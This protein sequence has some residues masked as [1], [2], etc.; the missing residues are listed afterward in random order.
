[1]AAEKKYV[2][3]IAGRFKN[4]PYLTWDLINEPSFS[5]PKRPW[6]GNTPNADRTEKAAWNGW[7]SERYRTVQR[8]AEAWGVAVEDLPAFGDI[9]LPAPEELTLQRYGAERQVRAIDYNLFAQSMFARWVK[10]M[11]GAIRAAGA[12][13]AVTVGQDEGGVTDRVLNQFWGGAGVAMT[14]NHSW[15]RDDALLWDSVAAKRPDLPSIIGETGV[16]PAWRADAAWRWDEV[17]AF[18]LFERKM[19]LGLAGG[20]SGSLYWDWSR[21]DTFGIKRGDGSNKTWMDVLEAMCGFAAKAVRYMTGARK[22]DVA[23]VLPQSLQLSQFNSYALEA[24]QKAVRALFHYARATAYA[25]G[26]YQPDLLGDP[27][28]IILPSPW[29]LNETAWQAVLA[30]ARAGA[31]VL[32]SGRIDLDEYFHATARTPVEGYRPALLATRENALT[33]PGGQARLSYSGDKCT[34]L[35]RGELPDGNTFTPV[36]LGKGKVLYFSLPLELNDDLAAIG[37]V[38]RFALREAGVRQAYTTATA[39]P[40]LLLAPTQFDAATL[41]VLTS[42]SSG[43][44]DVSFRDTASG[45]EFAGR[46]APGRAA[47]LLIRKDGEIAA[48]YNWTR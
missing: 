6:K 32:V 31:T 42:E 8:L 25:V 7:L 2:A 34:Y 38:Y 21:G 24:Q 22:P 41:Y 35:E 13:Q 3:A 39:D 4:C 10:E 11:I 44:G 48:S 33:W 17:T 46:I 47:L 12:T 37:E 9:P 20:N 30:K 15:W 23:I 36:P 28:L 19:A 40:G 18:G 14:V 45:R 43:A 27:K 26:E 5:N 16:Q 29:V 1:M